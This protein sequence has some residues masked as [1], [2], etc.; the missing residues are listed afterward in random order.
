MEEINLDEFINIEKEEIQ[1]YDTQVDNLKD[2]IK[3]LKKLKK[4]K[5]KIQQLEKQRSEI[6]RNIE[7]R[8]K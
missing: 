3:K 7:K 2:S 5:D 6:L 1:S 4:R 8:H